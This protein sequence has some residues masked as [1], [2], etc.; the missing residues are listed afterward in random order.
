[1]IT[2]RASIGGPPMVR[3][4][5]DKVRKFRESLELTQLYLA[6]SVGVTTDTI[7]RWENR[8]YPTIKKENALKLAEA[9]EV[10]LEEILEDHETES[11]EKELKEEQQETDESN[12][13]RL[14]KIFT[15]RPLLVLT[16]VCGVIIS[17]A[18]WWSFFG[19]ETI[20]ITAHRF[21]PPHVAPGLPFPVIISVETD[22]IGSL[23]L[24]LRESVPQECTP[25]KADPAFTAIDE[26]TGDLKW[27]YQTDMQKITFCYMA[28]IN[29][30]AGLEKEL[31]FEG[32]VTVRKG[33]STT[34]PINGPNTLQLSPLHWADANG[35]EKIDDEE[36]LTVYDELGKMKDI[37]FGIEQIEDIWSGNGYRW[38]EKTKKF[39]VLKLSD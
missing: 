17:S 37:N 10:S 14:P 39:V 26:K 35:D 18:F 29:P 21:L 3:I 4:D 13:N 11:Q 12:E 16:L 2:D 19:H 24:I 5:G 34:T 9:L 15:I 7:S 1:M 25:I 8:R 33:R 20:N 27:I 28:T 32:T 30:G 31:Q 6:T 38:D 22:H 23:S 36:I